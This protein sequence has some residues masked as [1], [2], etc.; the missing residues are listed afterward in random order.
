LSCFDSNSFKDNCP[1]L[2][3]EYFV[4]RVVA[5]APLLII[6][7]NTSRIRLL[8]PYKIF[9]LSCRQNMDLA[10]FVRHET[11]LGLAGS[12]LIL[13]VIDRHT[14]RAGQVAVVCNLDTSGIPLRLGFEFG[15]TLVLKKEDRNGLM[16][17]FARGVIRTALVEES[18]ADVGIISNSTAITK[19]AWLTFVAVNSWT[20]LLS[21]AASPVLAAN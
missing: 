10:H 15:K 11:P 12:Q 21:S 6:N 8:D 7:L 5:L 20:Y 16:I 17:K 2:A 13:L 18:I 9:V 1:P 3:N 4:R 19:I 14:L